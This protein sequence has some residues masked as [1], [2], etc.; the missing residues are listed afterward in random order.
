M[1]PCA[2]VT[3]KGSCFLRTTARTTR[4]LCLGL[5]PL[6]MPT[7]LVAATANV[8]IQPTAFSPNTVTINVNDRVV[9]TW[10]SDSNGA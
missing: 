8:N 10:V 4:R 3:F 9:W 2:D 6:V 7:A 5:L 1:K